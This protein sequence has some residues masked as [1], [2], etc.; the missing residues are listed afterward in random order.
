[1]KCSQCENKA[2]FTDPTY[3]KDHFIEYFENTVHQ[4]IKEYKLIKKGQKVCVAVSG[5][6]D[7]LTLL[8]ILSQEYDV[9]GLAIDEGIKGYR[10]HTLTNLKTFCQ[11]HN[12]KL[13]IQSFK[14]ETGYTLDNMLIKLNEKPCT[15]CGTFRRYLLNKYSQEFDVIATGHNLDD[16]CQA[17]MMNI[18]RNNTDILPR[19]GPKTGVIEDKKLTQRIKPLYF[20]TEKEVMAYA[21]LKGI[22]NDFNECPNVANSFRADVRDALNIYEQTHKSTKKNIVKSYLS[23]KDRLMDN[24]DTTHKLL[25]C[26]KCGEPSQNEVCSACLTKERLAQ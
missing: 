16:E 25:Y 17:I 11:K 9:T 26:M 1:M 19:L 8:Y 5:G 3:C 18:L 10:E 2:I 14:D 13:N 7:S 23:M 22:T 20:L 12:V 4:T 15:V 24:V 6:K 21:I